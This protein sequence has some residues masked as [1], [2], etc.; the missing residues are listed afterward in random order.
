MPKISLI[1]HIYNKEVLR[2]KQKR[3]KKD[4]STYKLKEAVEISGK[5][6]KK[7]LKNLTLT[8]H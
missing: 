2:G 1:E 3:K 6:K 4:T 8:A 5:Y 7:G